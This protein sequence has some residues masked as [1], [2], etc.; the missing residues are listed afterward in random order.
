MNAFLIH[1]LLSEAANRF[2]DNKSIVLMN[3]SINYENL[4][5]K[6][7]KLAKA[8]YKEG[9]SK[10]ECVGLIFNKSIES[11]IAVFSILKTGASY[12]PIDPNSPISR[13]KYIINACKIKNLIV[14]EKIINSISGEL[15]ED[16]NISKIFI[17]S[18][19]SP[20]L[21]RDKIHHKFIYWDDIFSSESDVALGIQITDT[22]PAY[23]LF[24]SGSTGTP[25][26]CC[27]FTSE[28]TFIH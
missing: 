17:P 10:G 26:G 12:V 1:H 2:P 7:N 4:E 9:A 27:N 25:K 5:I 19:P 6:S 28:F 18:K 16:Q 14:S 13:I 20:D 11:I 23:I 8:L 15:N 22:H 24:T 21:I 3:E